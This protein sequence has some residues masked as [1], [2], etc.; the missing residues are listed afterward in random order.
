MQRFENS[1]KGEV[2]SR[3]T[4]NPKK[5]LM[6]PETKKSLPKWYIASLKGMT[7]NVMPKPRPDLIR[8]SS[9]KMHAYQNN[10][11]NLP[12]ICS[13]SETRR[14]QIKK[15][16]SFNYT[17][18]QDSQQDSQGLSQSLL[19][20]ETDS[21]KYGRN[22]R[23][24]KQLSSKPNLSTKSIPSKNEKALIQNAP[25]SLIRHKKQILVESEVRISQS[26]LFK[27]TRVRKYDQM[28]DEGAHVENPSSG[29]H[30]DI[31]EKQ[32]DH[33]IN[34]AN[35]KKL[36]TAMVTYNSST[37]QTFSIFDLLHKDAK[38]MK[39]I[40]LIKA[41][42]GKWNESFK[43]LQRAI[44]LHEGLKCIGPPYYNH[45]D[46][47][48]TYYHFGV[49][50]NWLCKS[51]LALEALNKSHDLIRKVLGD[52]HL[53]VASVLFCIGMIKGNNGDYQGAIDS[54]RLARSI[55][56]RTQ[57]YDDTTTS[58]S[59]INFIHLRDAGNTKETGAILRRGC[60]WHGS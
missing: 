19:F 49:T 29:H 13:H 30:N 35:S 41:R 31:K 52:D 27:G 60:T 37:C 59:L 8:S 43:L 11:T 18:T 51:D 22:H 58:Q 25:K 34:V 44:R 21:S 20:K 12:E 2:P 3:E 4:T 15:S 57:G 45:L 47:A 6:D 17:H 54:L 1:R 28:K 38:K 26:V 24:N 9:Y 32:P 33:Q 39:E 16:E 53:D 7:N 5:N 46:V 56:R 23:R 55:Q 14:I 40:A 36:N 48:N 42:D 50:L 10:K